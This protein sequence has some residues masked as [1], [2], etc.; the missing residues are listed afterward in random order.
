MNMQREAPVLYLFILYLLL[1][2]YITIIRIIIRIIMHRTERLCTRSQVCDAYFGPGG[3]EVSC[4]PPRSQDSGDR[5]LSDTI[6]V[7]TRDPAPSVRAS[8]ETRTTY[9]KNV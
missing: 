7:E 5:A 9:G 6:S 8:S 1:D 3:S 4:K 2:T